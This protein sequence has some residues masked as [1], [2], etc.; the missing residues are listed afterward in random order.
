[1][2]RL[3]LV[4]L[5]AIGAV[6]GGV[7]GLFLLG[8][9]S[10]P[11]AEAV[12]AEPSRA[13]AEAAA[14]DVAVL[15]EG[16][17]YEQQVAGKPVFRLQGARFTTDRS[18]T[19]TLDDVL[20]VL[21]RED[22]P[23]EVRSRSATY[24]PESKNA[25]LV[26]DVKVS[27]GE[28]WELSGNRLDL[29]GETNTIVSRGG[30]I[31]FRRGEELA[32]SA[33]RLRYRMDEQVLVLE[34]Q[35]EVAGERQG[36][37]RALGLKAAKMTWQ[38]DGSTVSAEGGVLLTADADR[39]EAHRIDA[40][41]RSGGAELE[42]ATAVGAVRGQLQ[43][44][45]EGRLA[46]VSQRAQ[47]DFDETSGAPSSVLLAGESAAKPAELL[48]TPAAGT[49]RRLVAPV[50]QAAL[51]A[52]RP[53][54][55]AATG[56]VMLREAT[57]DG[58]ERRATAEQ[59]TAAFAPDGELASA[60]LLRRVRL[61]DGDWTVTGDEATLAPGGVRGEV[62]GR[63]AH[64][65]G[66]RGEMTAPTMRFDR[67]ASRLD[68]GTGVR[69]TFRPEASPVASGGAPGAALPVAVE[70]REATFFDAPRRSEMRGDVRVA[71]GDSLLFADRLDGDEEK[72]VAIAIGHV[73]TQW[74]DRPPEGAETAPVVTVITAERFE[75]RR[76]AGE[77]HYSGEVVVRQERREIFG[78]ELVVE[79][80]DEGKARRLLATGSV[81]IEDRASGRSVSGT[82]AD[83]D[84]AA[85]Q[86]IVLGEPV[87]LRD[88]TGTVLRGRRALFDERTG[89]SRLL[90]DES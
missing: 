34:G 64:A 73:R 8:R 38:R 20:L 69:V 7:T 87:V 51:T 68:A 46:F 74:T 52:G 4:L 18:G 71:Q 40:R 62:R 2:R 29:V 14:E 33:R 75:Y 66:E 6:L 56:G 89:T 82:S 44:P 80:D 24:D 50:V 22:R 81:R 35:V 47:V 28:G 27:G 53:T 70:A 58:G 15:S 3:R 26:G 54:E 88:E 63:P 36:D 77:A 41:L 13:R 57:A 12:P 19:V 32:G 72:S 23:Y 79:L 11:P 37:G 83:Y 21:Y 84:L 61:V 65:V 10:R 9:A 43:T 59:V 30:R 39:V 67:G 5:A 49:K 17:D 1:M 31:N 86:A 42:T 78:D 45:E 76:Q 60:Q 48:W 55:A 16:F 85:G 90:S 25:E